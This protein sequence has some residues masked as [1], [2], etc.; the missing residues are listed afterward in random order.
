MTLRPKPSFP[1]NGL[2][3]PR[4]RIGSFS[5]D[6]FSLKQ[7]KELKVYRLLKNSYTT[8]NLIIF[9][10]IFSRPFLCREILCFSCDNLG[11]MSI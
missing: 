8:L 5:I 10:K 4:M 3:Q 7:K 2:Q 9:F 1:I 6:V 11:I